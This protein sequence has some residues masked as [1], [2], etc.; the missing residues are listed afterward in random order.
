MGASH[1]IP[2]VI[3]WQ[4]NAQLF[5]AFD[6]LCLQQ[7][8]KKKT[9]GTSST[10]VWPLLLLPSKFMLFDRLEKKGTCMSRR[11]FCLLSSL[12]LST[13]LLFMLASTSLPASAH[14]VSNR[15]ETSVTPQI[16]R[17]SV[18]PH[19]INNSVICAPYYSTWSTSDPWIETGDGPA[20]SGCGG[21]AWEARTP[22]TDTAWYFAGTITANAQYHLRAFITGP[23]NAPMNYDIYIDNRM[24]QSCYYNQAQG[25]AWTTVGCSFSVNIGDYSHGLYI[26]IRSGAASP[27]TLAAS[28]IQ[29]VNG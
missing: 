18:T 4:R 12:G 6:Q 21:Q 16:S 9:E 11:I 5:C 26:K 2:T 19:D 27:H 25:F 23:A 3:N 1:F 8:E 17:T 22:T 29:V 13:F 7:D 15:S 10:T 24:I 28:A 14:E 20:S